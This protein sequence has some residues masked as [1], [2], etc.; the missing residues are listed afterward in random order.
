MG[1][2]RVLAPL[3]R[4]F[5]PCR[6]CHFSRKEI[7]KMIYVIMCG[8]NYSYFEHPKALAEVHGEPL[9]G[10]TV[11][12]LKEAG[13]KESEIK[14]TGSD[15]RLEAFGPEVLR[16]KNDFKVLPD[17][18]EGSWLNAFIRVS[19]PVCY[20]FG[21]VYYTDIGI[22][23]IVAHNSGLNTLFGTYNK[24]LKPWDEPLAF[25]VFDTEAFFVG[26]KAVKRLSDQGRCNRHPIVW[27]LYRFLNGIDVNVHQ[28]NPDTYVNIPDGG[29][30]VDGPED[31]KRVEQYY[32]G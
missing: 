26:V 32:A 25:K 2:Q 27:E 20:L 15:P 12:L 23:K 7:Y 19:V 1:T 22:K 10:R 9:V 16:H 29:M 18:I 5:D 14:I 6:P 31:L 13:I 4:R 17:R 8:G 11:R 24:D 21:D 30:D 3:L 28:V